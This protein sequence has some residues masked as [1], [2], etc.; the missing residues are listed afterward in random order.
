LKPVFFKSQSEFHKW[1]KKNSKKESEL[2]VGFYKVGSGKQSISYKEAVD[3]A[4]CFG[5]IDGIRNS[6][7]NKSY[8]NRFTPRKPRSNWSNVNI[9]RVKELIKSGKMQ[10]EG[11]QA[12]EKR[13]EKR[14]GVY[15]FERKNPQ[16][17]KEFEKKFKANKKAW[18]FFNSKAPWYKRT[19]TH[20][21][22]S[23]KKEETR[24]KRLETLINDSEKGRNISLLIKT[25]K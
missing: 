14:S 1:L 13:D 16:L 6:I 2:F 24:L 3:E 4:L 8:M 5:W 17:G 7:D 22:I 18:E 21:V 15:S 23:A 19:S 20:W 12:F 25:K 10:P 11:L 9:Q